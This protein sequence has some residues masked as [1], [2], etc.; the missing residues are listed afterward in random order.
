M[1][2]LLKSDSPRFGSLEDLTGYILALESEDEDDIDYE[3]DRDDWEPYYED[4]DDDY[5]EEY[6]DEDNDD[7]WHDIYG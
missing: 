7:D 2:Y 4:F 5:K 1:L 3:D 6:Y